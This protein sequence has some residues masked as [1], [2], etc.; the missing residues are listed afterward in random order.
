MHT[1]PADGRRGQPTPCRFARDPDDL[2]DLAC[3]FGVD[4]SL[5]GRLPMPADPARPESPWDTDRRGRISRPRATAPLDDGSDAA[6]IATSLFLALPLLDG[7]PL[8]I[9]LGDSRSPWWMRLASSSFSDGTV[10]LRAEGTTLRVHAFNVIAA[11]YCTS[12]ASRGVSFIGE[13]GIFL[14]LWST[15]ARGFDAWLDELGLSTSAEP[16]GASTRPSPVIGTEASR[17]AAP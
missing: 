15:D 3:S 2:R 11:T 5:D 9:S 4:S 10:T 16:A 8:F 17:E 12:A 1:I 14:S 13:S 6:S 7:K